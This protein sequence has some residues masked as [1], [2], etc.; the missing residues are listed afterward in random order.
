M[1]ISMGAAA[2]AF[3]LFLL[4][5]TLAAQ[6]TGEIRGKVTEEGG[7]AL[8][9]VAITA[10]SPNLQGPRTTV[11]DRNG[12]F[13]LALLPV[14]TY[15]VTFELPGFEKLALTGQDVRLGFTVS[16]SVVLKPATVSEQVTV[17]A[18]TPLIDKTKTDNSYRLNRDDLALVPTQARTIA[19][20]VDLTPG[21]TG[22]RSST[23][24][25]GG[26][27]AVGTLVSGETGL[28]SFRGEGDSGNNWLV[29]GLT[30]RGVILNDPGVRVNYDA[31]E[32]V[33]IVSDGF[34]PEWG[35]A[36]GGF[37]NIVTKSGG[38]AFHGELGGLVQPLSFRAERKAQFSAVNVPESS[39]QQYYGNLG[40]PLIKDKLWFFV[41]DNFFAGLDRNG[42]H[43]IGWLTVPAGEMRQSA[44]NIFG[45]LTFTPVKNHALSLSGTWDEFLHQS[46]GIG[47][48][49]AYTE[50]T[51]SR[52]SYRLNYRGV[53][54]RNTLL[55][56]AWGQN[57][58]DTF[59]QPLSGDYGPPSYYWADIG[60]TTNNVMAGFQNLDRRS[61]VAINLTQYLDLG[62]WGDHEVKAGLS[63]Y[64]NKYFEAWLFTGRDADP[65][66]GNGYDNGIVIDWASPGIPLD[67]YE[68]GPQGNKNRIRGYG[69]YAEDNIALGR[70][71]VTLGLRT[72]TEQAF[73]SV[74]AQLWSWG[75][76]DFL[77]PRISL[78]YDLSGN[79]RNVLKFG[80]GSY[81]APTSIMCLGFLDS[82][83]SYPYRLYGWA[84]PEDPA[85]SQLADPANWTLLVERGIGAAE[86][87]DPNLK[88]D[89]TNKFLL[90]FDR[91]LGTNWALK[92]RGVYSHSKN[93]I[94]DLRLYDPEAPSEWEMLFT[95][96]E[97]KRRNYRALEVE[98][99]GRIRNRLT[100][101]ASY[102]W[103]QA[104]GT[105]PGNWNEGLSWNVPGGYYDASL[106][107]DRPLMPESS[108]NKALYDELFAGL[109]G[110]G[111]GEEGWYGFLPY[112]IDHVVKA[113][114]TYIAPYGFTV[115]AN[116]EYLSGYHWE[117]K[118]LSLG[119]GG[120]CLFPEGRGGR[121]TPP[122]TY[123]DLMVGKDFRLSRGLILNLGVDAYNVFDSQRPVS[124]VKED[125]SLFG[126]V[127]ARQLP[128]WTQIKATLKF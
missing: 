122:H 10:R 79:G 43:S 114:V 22:V 57:K 102:T 108:A 120:Y 67:L 28:P 5:G 56:G 66:P 101:N 29:D 82:H 44:N 14:G 91:Q 93:L 103:S 75:M 88:P 36:L 3:M 40:G 24:S 85:E 12:N 107:G 34:A 94:E 7:E 8:P 47:L 125:N 9:G 113:F 37:V 111:I 110:R 72:D 116:V 109:G 89:R 74:G 21:V 53:L 128:R 48:P 105:S 119:Y 83:Y 100:L 58:N 39:P 52:Y 41:S 27:L 18:P 30:T 62:R 61:D 80:Y 77:Q 45:K 13:R 86:E 124:F 16:L 60:Q 64:D 115:S 96:F 112:S 118:G 76:E 50:T 69:F 104:K 117:K 1:K 106:F 2:A 84:G 65:W 59:L 15:A 4:T 63:F 123:V 54:S 32:E 35:Q 51:Y 11:S 97:L 55:T 73:D 49:E 31:W 70:V 42:E 81:A 98:L 6:Q 33:Q 87:L 92:L 126:Q 19:D 26:N 25:G 38:N 95:N 71:S 78:A 23:V 127:W 17:V 68:P 121:T 99:N 20:I 46:G 90:E